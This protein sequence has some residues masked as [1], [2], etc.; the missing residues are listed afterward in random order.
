[1][2]A[3]AARKISSDDGDAA[4]RAW[5]SSSASESEVATA[6]RY[7]LQLLR[8][9]APG[10]SVEV[11]VPPYGA[12]QVIPGPAHTRGTPPAVIEMTPEMWLTIATGADTYLDA[13]SRG[14]ISASGQRT[15]LTAWLPIWPLP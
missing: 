13:L 8:Q 11:R 12:A 9:D 15:D 14:D 6:V 7:C 2:W 5:T 3:V 1:V 10:A 4:L